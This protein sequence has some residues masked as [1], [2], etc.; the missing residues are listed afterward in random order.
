VL[1][2]ACEDRTIRVFNLSNDLSSSNIG[3]RRKALTRG[4]VDVAFG[5]SAKQLV[6]LTKGATCL[7]LTPGTKLRFTP[8]W[9]YCEHASNSFILVAGTLDAASLSMYDPSSN[10]SSLWEVSM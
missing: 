1:A 9:P 7:L 8:L 3:F 6:A 10:F 2:T 4:L 5:Q